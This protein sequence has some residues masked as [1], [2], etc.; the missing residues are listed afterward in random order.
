VRVGVRCQQPDDVDV[1]AS[2]VGGEIGGLRRRRDDLQ[3]LTAGRAG[4]VVLTTGDEEACESEEV[5]QMR[6]RWGSI[7]SA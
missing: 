4:P 3:G 5:Q 1:V 7:W 2:D 6:T